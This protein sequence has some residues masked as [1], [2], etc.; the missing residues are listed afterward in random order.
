MKKG[1]ESRDQTEIFPRK[2]RPCQ[3]HA[4]LAGSF[5]VKRILYREVDPLLSRKAIILEKRKR[6]RK[7]KRRKRKEKEELEGDLTGRK[8]LRDIQKSSQ[9]I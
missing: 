4:H 8:V 6:K 5:L 3:P 1:I 7:R 9:M 2:A